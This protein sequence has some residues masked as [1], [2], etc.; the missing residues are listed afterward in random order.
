MMKLPSPLGVSPVP[1]LPLTSCRFM[2]PN[3]RVS[4]PTHQR[5]GYPS[6]SGSSAEVRP[7]SAVFVGLVGRDAALQHGVS[8]STMATR[9][10]ST[11]LSA[12]RVKTWPSSVGS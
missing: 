4:R 1:P 12:R 6:N 2:A 8:P 5:A 7:F 11:V 9:P 3:R 10:S